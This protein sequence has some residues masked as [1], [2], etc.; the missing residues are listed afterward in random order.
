MKVLV[1]GAVPLLAVALAAATTGFASTTRTA[2]PGTL[3]Y[4]EGQVTLNGRRMEAKSVGSAVLAPKQILDTHDGKAEVLLTPGVFVRLGDN[5]QLQMLSPDLTN[6]RVRLT[7]GSAMLEV[8]ELF[9]QNNLAISEGDT[10]TRIDQEGLYDF[11]ANH[12]M[13]GVLKG[14]A[15]VYE[16][17]NQVTLRKGHELMF[18]DGQPLKAQKLDE[19]ALEASSLYRWSELRSEYEA[20]ANVNATRT[21]LADG[22]WYGPGWYW[23]PYWGLYSFIPPIGMLYS[24][25][26]WG[27][28]SPGW[29]VAGGPLLLR[30]G[31]GFHGHF[32]H[33]PHFGHARRFRAQAMPMPRGGMMRGRFRR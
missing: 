24:P 27:F 30:P 19:K 20:Q 23:A 12:A 33:F 10:T 6:T 8:D 4:V 13:V 1:K 32:R 14:K 29:V 28:Y 7:N 22:G 16:S 11:N 5:S 21:V 9:K 31:F 2:V 18:A 3:N 15:T 26:G 17:D 25:F